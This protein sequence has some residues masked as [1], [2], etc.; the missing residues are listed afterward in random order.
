MTAVDNALKARVC[1]SLAVGA[2]GPYPHQTFP[3]IASRENLTIDQ[4]KAIA[5][6]HGWPRPSSLRR[7]ADIL[8]QTPDQPGHQLAMATDTTFAELCLDD[9]HPDP[10]NVRDDLGDLTELAHSIRDVGILQPIVARRDHHQQLV[11]VMGHRRHAAARQAGLDT[12]PVLIRNDMDPDDVLAA[13]IVENS[14]R[15]DLDPIEEARAIARLKRADKASDAEV[16]HRISKSQAYVSGRLALLS[17]TPGQQAAVRAGTLPLQ[18]AVRL[19]RDQGGL[20]RP[21]MVGKKSA[22]HLDWHH[23]LAEKASMLCAEPRSQQE[24]SGPPRRRRLRSLLGRRHPRRRTH[25]RHREPSLSRVDAG[26]VTRMPFAVRDTCAT[27][28]LGPRERMDRLLTEIRF[29]LEVWRIDP[30]VRAEC[31][32]VLTWLA[33]CAD[34]VARLARGAAR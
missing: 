5:H 10:D 15:L 20:T 16:A 3:A 7:A 11:I 1:K 19:G 29:S 17:L 2:E 14:Q 31:E 32:H 33:R 30:V 28:N 22:A 34:D 4:V 23:P 6:A 26:R 8:T 18:R 9:L 21:G 13:M 24:T 25:P 27:R 12:V